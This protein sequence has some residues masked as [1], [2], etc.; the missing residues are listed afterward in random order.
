MT[1]PLTIPLAFWAPDAED[2]ERQARAWAKAEP[3]I[4]R[5]RSVVVTANP[6]RER[7]TVTV[8]PEWVADGVVLDL[9]L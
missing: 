5:L 7:W 3:R 2:A 9:G 8:E 1:N 4:V 6:I